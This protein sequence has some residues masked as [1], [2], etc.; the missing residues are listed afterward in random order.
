M[1]GSATLK[2][3]PLY[4]TE[5]TPNEIVGFENMP[6]FIAHLRICKSATNAGE[7]PTARLNKE[8]GPANRDRVAAILAELRANGFFP[9]GV[10]GNGKVIW[11]IALMSDSQ[12]K[13]EAGLKRFEEMPMAQLQQES[14]QIFRAIRDEDVFAEP[15]NNEIAYEEAY[16]R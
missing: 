11:E 12:R 10:D 7:F 2:S 8:I 5:L 9:Q 13:F 3:P 1:E 14:R 4:A 15:S 6:I 16:G